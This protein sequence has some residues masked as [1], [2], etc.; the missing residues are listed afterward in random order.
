MV[1]DFDANSFAASIYIFFGCLLEVGIF[2]FINLIQ[3]DVRQF[4]VQ[5][6][7]LAIW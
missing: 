6:K 3:Y 4:R 7:G 2:G 5:S 1:Y